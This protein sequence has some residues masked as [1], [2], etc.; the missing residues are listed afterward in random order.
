V[1]NQYAKAVLGANLKDGSTANSFTV[2]DVASL[3]RV[4]TVSFDSEIAVEK[5]NSNGI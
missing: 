1:P 4:L 5:W 3:E 2:S